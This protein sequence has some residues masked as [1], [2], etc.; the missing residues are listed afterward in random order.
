MT[1]RKINFERV[2]NAR[3]MGGIV[4]AEG[5][6]VRNNYLVRCGTLAKASDIDM[7]QFRFL[8]R[9]RTIIDFRTDFER[10]LAPDRKV[11]DA[12]YYSLPVSDANGEL[13]MDLLDVPGD[14]IDALIQFSKTDRG[15]T[16]TKT[17]YQ[18]TLNEP[19]CQKSYARF[20]D[21]LIERGKEGSIFWH[22]TQGKDRTGLAAMMLLTALGV[23][24]K[25]IIDDFDQT[26]AF[27]L[28]RINTVIRRLEEAGGTEEDKEF[29]R[30]IVGAN[31]H[32][33]QYALDDVNKNYGSLMAYMEQK[34]DVTP[35]KV[36]QLRRLFLV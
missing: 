27:F 21:I 13:W 18:M 8:Y 4:G 3:Q 29:V 28:K 36:K 9:A 7:D 35:E 16:M 6:K 2:L 15:H 17:M 30:T 22:C 33:L 11:L 23:D 34:I 20:F 1:D 19:A 31:L 5:R 25:T 12:E 26:N 24:Q 14:P 32:S 10:E